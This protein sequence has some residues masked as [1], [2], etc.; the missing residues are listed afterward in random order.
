[1][2]CT[3]VGRKVELRT[4]P[5]F[6][7]QRAPLHPSSFERERAEVMVSHASGKRLHGQ[8]ATSDHG[9]DLRWLLTPKGGWI[10]SEV[11]ARK[12]VCQTMGRGLW[13]PL[14]QT[15]SPKTSS[16]LSPSP[17]RPAPSELGHSPCVNPRL[18]MQGG[19]Q[20]VRGDSETEKAQH[21]C[22]PQSPPWPVEISLGP[23]AY[24]AYRPC[25]R[26]HLSRHQAVTDLHA[27]FVKQ[28]AMVPMRILYHLRAA[29]R[30][31][32]DSRTGLSDSSNQALTSSVLLPL[33]LL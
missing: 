21:C 19:H 5:Y 26:L 25:A 20:G 31:G 12:E 23:T 16:L 29:L 32:R 14:P 9:Q 11:K 30:H 6:R 13:K 7:M 8:S 15:A 33:R 18:C 4:P 17:Q 2:H 3:K 28:V 24:T 22:E 10:F 27:S 1:M